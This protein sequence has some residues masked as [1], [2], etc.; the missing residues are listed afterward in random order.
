MSAQPTVTVEV[1]PRQ[2]VVL[3]T[4]FSGLIAGLL[5]VLAPFVLSLS[6][7]AIGTSLELTTAVSNPWVWHLVF[8]ALFGGV[9][10]VLVH[11]RPLWHYGRGFLGPVVGLVFG[12]LSWGAAYALIEPLWLV[13]HG[14]T[15]MAIFPV[16]SELSL[17]T[18]AVWG[19]LVGLVSNVVP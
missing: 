19:T 11:S 13:S 17:V 16:Y 15:S 4:M 12:V 3:K 2:D 1:T 9:F 6:P 7:L 18:Y 5:L 10:G 8:S 14:V